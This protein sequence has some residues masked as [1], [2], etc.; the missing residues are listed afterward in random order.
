MKRLLQQF[1][2]CRSDILAS[3]DG[4]PHCTK[5]L[6]VHGAQEAFCP[7]RGS[8]VVLSEGL[9]HHAVRSSLPRTYYQHTNSERK[10]IPSSE[11]MTYTPRFSITNQTLASFFQFSLH[12]CES[13]VSKWFTEQMHMQLNFSN[14]QILPLHILWTSLLL[15]FSWWSRKSSH[16]SWSI[17]WVLLAWP[18]SHWANPWLISWIWIS[19]WRWMNTRYPDFKHKKAQ[20]ALWLDDRQQ[21]PWAEGQSWMQIYREL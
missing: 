4:Q 8:H 6:V 20:K 12:S 10:R 1:M 17:L 14:T 9:L 19:A 5:P 16:C 15:Q 7:P 11:W 2:E 18:E 3:K 13:F 21:P